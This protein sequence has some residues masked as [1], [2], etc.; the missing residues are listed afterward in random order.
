MRGQHKNVNSGKLGFLWVVL[1][2]GF[3]VEPLNHMAKCFFALN[4]C[5]F[6]GNKIQ[7]I[8]QLEVIAKN[9]WHSLYITT[10]FHT[11]WQNIKA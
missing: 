3:K 10:L 6:L 4:N 8:Q 5:P 11:L 2:A 1:E 9:M 7:L